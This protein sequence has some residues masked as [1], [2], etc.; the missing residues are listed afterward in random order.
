M[1][2]PVS[3]V[4]AVARGRVT[5]WERVERIELTSPAVADNIE[6]AALIATNGVL[7]EKAINIYNNVDFDALKKRL[8]R[9]LRTVDR[10]ILKPR[11]DRMIERLD[12]NWEKMT[13][14]QIRKVFTDADKFLRGAAVERALPQWNTKVNATLTTVAR[15]ARR[16]IRDNFLPRMN[17]AYRRDELDALERLSEQQGWFI[18]DRQKAISG[19]LTNRGRTIV[20]DGLTKGLGRKEIGKRLWNQLPG[21][22]EGMGRNYANVVA[23]NAM[24]RARS[25]AEIKSYQSAGIELLEAQA[26]LDERTTEI[27]RFMDGQIVEVSRC[28]ELSNQAAAVEDPRDIYKVSPFMEVIRNKKGEHEIQTRNG[29]RIAQITR[30]GGGKVDDRGEQKAF[31]MGRQLPNAN[32]GPPP[33]HHACRTITVPRVDSWQ[34]PDSFEPRAGPGRPATVTPPKPTRRKPALPPALITPPRKKPP[35]HKPPP[36]RPIDTHPSPTPKKP[37]PIGDPL[38]LDDM[39]IPDDFLRDPPVRVYSDPNVRGVV[40]N[41]TRD[42][43]GARAFVPVKNPRLI[44][45]DDWAQIRTVGDDILLTGAGDSSSV[46]VQMGVRSSAGA[47]DLV[48]M[49]V[50]PNMAGREVVFRMTTKTGTD[51]FLRVI[52]NQGGRR[53]I[54]HAVKQLQAQTWT[55]KQAR[56]WLNKAKKDG[57]IKT[58][59]K[60]EDVTAAVTDR[61]GTLPVAPKPKA[62]PKAST[63]RPAV[64]ERP[65][66]TPAKPNPPPELKGKPAEHVGLKDKVVK[67]DVYYLRPDPK[68]MVDATWDGSYGYVQ[69]M[70]VK[71]SKITPGEWKRAKMVDKHNP[72]LQITDLKLTDSD[73][74]VVLFN[75]AEMGVTEFPQLYARIIESELKRGYF[76]VREYIIHDARG[77]T[78][79]VRWNGARAKSLGSYQMRQLLENTMGPFKTGRNKAISELR[80]GIAE[81]TTKLKEFYPKARVD[82]SKGNLVPGVSIEEQAI[83]RIKAVKKEINDRLAEARKAVG[84]RQLFRSEIAEVITDTLKRGASKIKRPSMHMHGSNPSQPVTQLTGK[85]RQDLGLTSPQTIERPGYTVEAQSV[86]NSAID[87]A[88]EYASDSLLNAVQTKPLPTMVSSSGIDRAWYSRGLGTG[89]RARPAAVSLPEHYTPRRLT[90]GGFGRETIRHELQHHIDEIGMGGHAARVARN[91]RI[92]NGKPIRIYRDKDEYALPG[93]WTDTYEAKVYGGD[94]KTL[95]FGGLSTKYTAKTLKKHLNG[96]NELDKLNMR[97]QSN[98]FMSTLS[99][100]LVAPYPGRI[101]Q[102]WQTNPD[103]VACFIA[104]MRGMFVPF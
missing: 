74:V 42:P 22:W 9:Q 68:K 66:P 87:E 94:Q 48:A 75:S 60:L 80:K 69:T 90:E 15:G 77:Q 36:Q 61:V 17:L 72:H 12:V 14:P 4:R 71:G 84:G 43:G 2:Q 102:N 101:A 55:E 11:L 91:G 6:G 97:T 95:E 57:W 21:M 34:V 28:A 85:A 10:V 81:S 76:G 67:S 54:D 50:H 8:V 20:E 83:A 64:P 5:L 3:I 99:E 100:N 51:Q 13:I 1:V 53:A 32:I 30:F 41:Y 78:F 7:I 23:A 103:Q 79:F 92:K 24:S 86:V 16:Q 93:R 49:A 89:A 56:A 88:L 82:W 33:Y 73:H 104:L 40:R 38:P 52:Q 59:T 62:L 65:K 29:D 18:R 26:V 58:G 44:T 31:I 47:Q 45:Y 96:V 46:L 19:A 70:K 39:T 63:K 37:T 35:K 25:W 98:E 27:C